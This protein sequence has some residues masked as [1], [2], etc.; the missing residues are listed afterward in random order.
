MGGD[1]WRAVHVVT[2]RGP[3]ASVHQDHPDLAGAWEAVD[4]GVE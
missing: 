1:T 3:G 2:E 4:L